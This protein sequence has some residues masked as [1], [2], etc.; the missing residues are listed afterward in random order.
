MMPPVAVSDPQPAGDQCLIFLSCVALA[1]ALSVNGIGSVADRV[2]NFPTVFRAL[3]T[4][5][6]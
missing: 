3:L 6:L 4:F 5:E 2:Q 1:N